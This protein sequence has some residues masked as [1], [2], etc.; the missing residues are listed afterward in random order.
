MGILG[1]VI[2]GASGAAVVNI[3]IN[4]IDNFSKTFALANLSIKKIGIGLG[5]L[6]VAGGVAIAGLVKKA[7][8]LE[9]AFRGVDVILGETGAA[10]AKFGKEVKRLSSE[11]PIQGG[12]IA[13]LNG[14]YEV[15]SAGITDTE[16]ATNLL[17]TA[18]EQAVA[19]NIDMSTSVK[20]LTS[21]MRGMGTEF[22]QASVVSSKLFRT[23]DLGQVTFEEL[24]SNIGTLIP[25][26]KTLGIELEE[27]LAGVTTLSGVT[28]DASEVTTQF[29]SIMGS[30]VKPTTEMTKVLGLLGFATGEAAIK[31][32]GFLGTLEAIADAAKEN[33]L[34]I[35]KII[36]RKEGLTAFF[37][38]VGESA[39]TYEENL[40]KITE[41][42]DDAADKLKIATDTMQADWTNA[43]NNINIIL[44]D[45]GSSLKETLAPVIQDLS[46]NLQ[47][48]TNF[49]DTDFGR[50]ITAATA[51]I[52]LGVVAALLL[53]GAIWLAT[54][55]FIAIGLAIIAGIFILKKFGDFIA[56]AAPSIANIF[57]DNVNSMTAVI[58]S[59]IN[60]LINAINAVTSFLGLSGQIKNVSFGRIARRAVGVQDVSAL[61]G[62]VSADK[63]DQL[64]AE[65]LIN[66]LSLRKLVDPLNIVKPSGVVNNIQ[67][68]QIFGTDPEEISKALSEELSAKTSL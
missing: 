52:L 47:S 27:V 68:D 45:F 6:G 28:G 2:G 63:L 43:V 57:I 51:L 5:L 26:A 10:E 29:R 61:G 13:V 16:D 39:E 64:A 8:N 12:R 36:G 18:T 7:A 20:A 17:T 48:L 59:F 55:P 41:S 21:I 65:K 3:L 44:E 31:E 25:F 22:S 67:I 49:L 66:I 40:N 4:G 32:L 50:S 46:E 1:A 23:V 53:A 34:S 54:L 15:I 35:G 9:T 37:Q 24:A 11:L 42:T 58:E 14:L 60:G 30:M 19:G 62:L 56:A 38:V 33:E